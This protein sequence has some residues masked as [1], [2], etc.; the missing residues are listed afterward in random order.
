VAL[1]ALVV[2]GVA[3]AVRHWET[4]DWWW[5]GGGALALL[6]LFGWWRELYLTTIGHR[7]VA[8]FARNRLRPRRR[9]P[10]SSTD[11]TVLLRIAPHPPRTGDALP[12]ATLAG[13]LYRY[14][15]RCAAVRVTSLN[16]GD[17]R[18]TWLG[19]TIRAADN[20][21]ALRARSPELR[22]A[23]TAAVTRRRL[24]DELRELG[25][26][27]D[28]VDK[29]TGPL[30]AGEARERWRGVQTNA[31]F[32]AAYRVTVNGALP[33]TLQGWGEPAV[34][35]EW[36]VLEMTGEPAQ[37]ALSVT[38]ALVTAER[39]TATPPLPGVISHTGLH[40]PVLAAMAPTS[41]SLACAFA[42]GHRQ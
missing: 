27:V 29:A 19:L 25:W 6:L 33:Q 20:L 30:P 39:P 36:T 13:Y 5:V 26:T 28:L 34:T 21:A 17:N 15:I 37:P 38:V 7:G 31:G 24:A 23:D 41:T 4:S 3:M 16:T 14:G 8:L 10:P 11:I 1:A 22:L 18:T 42:A 40:R 32:V 2:T 35:Q 9:Q 12:F